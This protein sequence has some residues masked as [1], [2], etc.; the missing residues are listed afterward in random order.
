MNHHGKWNGVVFTL[1]CLAAS[2]F[3]A[4]SLPS[5]LLPQ[6]PFAESRKQIV[7]KVI[8]EI[9]GNK[10]L[11][12]NSRT[13]EMTR[14]GSI[15][16][17][18]QGR[19]MT[20]CSSV[21][22]GGKRLALL[23]HP[24]VFRFHEATAT[25]NGIEQKAE[26]TVEEKNEKGVYL[27]K[28][29]VL[30][31][32][33]VRLSAEVLLPLDS[34]V[35]SNDM[36]LFFH[37]PAE[38]CLDK[39]M[40]STDDGKT[41]TH[42]IP[43]GN[44]KVFYSTSHPTALNF[45]PE[46]G[47]TNFLMRTGKGAVVECVAFPHKISCIVRPEKPK[48][49]SA[50]ECLLDL[51]KV[52]QQE[53]SAKNYSGLNW[54]NLEDIDVYDRDA[55][56]NLLANPSF[57][58]G[59]GCSVWVRYAGFAGHR[60]KWR[61][62]PPV[63][64][65]SMAKFGTHS[66]K[67]NTYATPAEQ[68]G[69]IR[70][71]YET[72][73]VSLFPVLLEAGDYMLSCY[74]KGNRKGQ[75]LNL[76]VSRTS[77]PKDRA[78]GGNLW[79][80]I[81]EARIAVDAE[82]KRIALPLKLGLDVPVLINFNAASPSADGAVWIDGVQLERGTSA[83]E[84]IGR[85]AESALLSSS[86]DNFLE[87]GKEASLRLRISAETPGR[88]HVT[89]KN[90]FSDIVYRKSFRFKNGSELQL[91]FTP[92][93]GIY[94]VKTEYELDNGKRTYDHHRFSVMNFLNNGHKLKNMFALDYG[95]VS[96]NPLFLRLL[97][98][99]RCLGYGSKGELKQMFREVVD[100]YHA[101]GMELSHA[102][103]CEHGRNERGKPYRARNWIYPNACMDRRDDR[104]PPLVKD[105]LDE[106]PSGK[107]TE[108]YLKRFEDAVAVR[109]GAFPWVRRWSFRG[110]D[111]AWCPGMAGLP[112]TEEEFEKYVKL[113]LAFYRGVKRGNPRAEIVGGQVPCNASPQSGIRALERFLKAVGNQARFDIFA[114]HFYRQG[115]EEPDLDADLGR[116]L[117]ML[118]RQGYPDAMVMLTE[119]GHYALYNIPQW[120]LQV[121]QWNGINTWQ[122]GP[123]SY[124]MGWSEKLI[125][126]RHARSWLA[127]LKYS[128]RI[129]FTT[130]SVLS[131]GT[132]HM[133][134]SLTPFATQKVVNTLGRLL[135]DAT[136]RKD[137]RFAPFVRCYLFEDAQKRPVA[138]VWNHDPRIDK[139]FRQGIVAAADFG[140]AKPEIFDMM[141]GRRSVSEKNG[142]ILW[143][144]SSFP[145]FLRGKPG[146]LSL[147]EKAFAD[148]T[149]VSA[150]D[151]AP[152]EMSLR[153]VSEKEFRL[154]IVNLL[155]RKF[156]DTLTVNRQTLPLTIES[157]GKKMIALELPKPLRADRMT[158]EEVKVGIGSK[159]SKTV[160]FHGILCSYV[161]GIPDWN[162]I[163]AVK[164]T[165]RMP[166]GGNPD[167]QAYYQLAWNRENLFIRVNVSDPRFF[168]QEYR[169]PAARY[170][171]DSLQI[172]F[173]TM[174]NARLKKER[175]FDM[176]DYDYAV[177]PNAEGTSAC[178]WRNHSPDIQLTMGTSAPPNLAFAPEIPVKFIRHKGGYSYEVAFPARFLLP[179]RLEN[180][181]A[182]GFSLFVNNRDERKPEGKH[183]GALTLTPDGTE[184]HNNPHL[185]PVMLLTGGALR[186]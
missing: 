88:A 39:T 22:L 8:P 152:I 2:A 13:L 130:L 132:F 79:I 11:F 85:I 138:A 20:V 119:G 97:E 134:I 141:E 163:P 149:P 19:V 155:S 45:F 123:V 10:I 29:T 63:I 168:H 36:R 170:D 87:F 133:D 140:G 82:W 76:W 137:I 157:A 15:V 4:D 54:R 66:L 14:S 147:F 120:E 111:D 64:D 9:R 80:P 102:H 166:S 89:I 52:V 74:V 37:F 112:A 84:Y 186:P 27:Q 73:S 38:V 118:D 26:F 128:P 178:V 162:R 86:A 172:Y 41:Q 177:F 151:L 165:N 154:E 90:F 50:M 44:N 81:N 46:D 127:A 99:S 156:K 114:I 116:L 95:T 150:S 28:C 16:L 159:L 183:L 129:S 131:G 5:D 34:E 53:K 62:G 3:G 180:G 121:S 125:T 176:D 124:D 32:G 42:K 103:M 43:L 61:C 58:Q 104:T 122:Y 68:R 75:K 175:G 94:I 142:K 83:T 96:A 91:D 25:T 57:E 136:F 143:A 51:Q 30:P 109:S 59:P 1:S 35:K 77:I 135:G 153:P 48:D 47:R 69:D 67:I 71:I 110:E 146:E 173:D 181:M 65:D 117:E 24:K 144:V 31:D 145:V 148:A 113:S 106:N 174:L 182:F 185:Y 56:R 70:G 184:S 105:I 12:G 40:L 33:Q 55:S 18:D 92:D 108:D 126:A 7:R 169:N 101:Y 164:F 60:K 107:L 17:F 93:R 139:G 100:T 21:V 160:A 6:A 72:G 23:D 115:P 158:R 78:R 161:T 171:N 179:I 49:C 98:R 167:F